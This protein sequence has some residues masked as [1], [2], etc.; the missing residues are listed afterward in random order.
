MSWSRVRFGGAEP[1]CGAWDTLDGRY[2]LRVAGYSRI[3]SLSA[4]ITSH[5]FLATAAVSLSFSARGLTPSSLP[6]VK[7]DECMGAMPVL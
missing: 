5:V 4:L 7:A 3:P 1:D 6:A 2:S